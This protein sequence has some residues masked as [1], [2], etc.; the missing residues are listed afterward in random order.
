M[1]GTDVREALRAVADTTDAPA[2]DQLAFQRLVRQ[3][4]RRRTGGRLLVG[5]AAAAVV[6]VGAT[7]LGTLP[8]DRPTQVAV[9]PRTVDASGLDVPAHLVVDGRLVAVDPQGER[10]DL[11]VAEDV[12][13]WTSEEVYYVDTESVLIRRA[14]D[15]SDEGPGGWTWGEPE[16][17][18]GPVQSARLSA[19]GR[20][21]GW[22]DLR[23][24]LHAVDLKAGADAAP[25]QQP[26]N[27]VLVDLAQG[28]G[29]P[30]VSQDGD[31]VL[32]TAAGEVVVP[33]EADG[34]GLV[35]TASRDLVAVVDRDDTTRL[36]DISSGAAELVDSVP[37]A[38]VLS[39]YGDA[40]VS[41]ELSRDDVAS[42][43]LWPGDGEPAVLP[44]PGSP[45]MAGW[46]DDDTV[47]VSTAEDGRDVVHAC[48]VAEP[49]R[50]HVLVE[51][52]GSVRLAR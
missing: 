6:A 17:V 33:T 29:A 23:E 45:Q 15:T 26:G 25:V 13:G 20:W 12:V 10:H 14:L 8:G 42:A 5:V 1:T 38:G 11:G 32:L 40:L 47:L 41:V 52:D 4:R 18:V 7:A 51:S 34:Y 22:I 28:T 27:T 46:A 16:E 31:L 24:R 35:A 30:L 21:L 9:A 3:E 44:V 49:S 36:Y 48:D 2:P 39:P 43:V 19:D 37:G 50:C